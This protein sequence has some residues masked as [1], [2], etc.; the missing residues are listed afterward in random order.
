MLSAI[1]K[2][3]GLWKPSPAAAALYAACAD[4]VRRE[5]YYDELA[6][7]DTVDGRFDLMALMISL[8]VLRLNRLNTKAGHALA[9]DLTDTLFA[10]MEESLRNMGVSDEGM[11]YRIRDMIQ[12]FMGRMRAYGDAESDD[13]LWVAA[14]GRNVYREKGAPGM[15]EALAA[16]IRAL[17]ARLADTPD[18]PLLLGQFGFSEE[19]P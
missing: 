6:V 15:A 7:A 4:E 18:A 14:L 19:T 11:R 3:L 13:A 16:R 17:R 2:K 5:T 10:D 1:M 12:A 8:L 9:Q